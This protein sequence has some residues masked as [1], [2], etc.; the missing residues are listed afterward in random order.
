MYRVVRVSCVLLTAVA[1]TA[2]GTPAPDPVAPPTARTTVAPGP[3]SADGI[4][5][6]YY[7]KDGNGGYDV[8]NYAVSVS[9]DPPAKQL[10]GDTVV[11]ATAT[12]ALTTF[13]LDLI[14]FDVTSVEVDGKPAEAAREGKHELVITPATPIAAGAKF[15]TRVRYAGVPEPSEDKGL[16]AGGWQIAKSGGAFAAGEPHVASHWFPVNDHPSDKATFRLAAR[17]PDGWSV[18][19]NGR[20]EPAVAEGGWTTYNWVEPTRIATYL[21]TIGI[22]KWTFERSTLADGTPVVNAYAPGTED[23]KAVQ[24]RMPEVLDF[25]STKFGPYPQSAAGGI[26]LNENI[27]FSLETQ[28][29]PIYAKWAELE[30]VV[31]ELAHQWFG[32]TVSVKTW[33]DICLNECFASYAQWLWAEAKEGV[34]LDERY[35][36]EV[37]RNQD[38]SR[39]W[40]RKLYDMGAGNEFTAVYDKGQLALHALRRQIGEDAFGKVLKDWIAAHKDGNASWPD[41]EDLATNVSGQ[42]LRPFFDAWF[43]DAKQ[44]ADEFLYPGTLR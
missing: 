1:F 2:C 22:D 17:V 33:A 3:A 19:S 34:N 25:L 13:N 40:N 5:D 9:Y 30:V 15:A 6:P 21:T 4:G 29:R 23:K 44:P 26:Y 20:E 37:A 10:T 42:N 28:G 31:H 41:F 12:S 18:V 8:E 39:F 32:D 43:R 27:G 38:R 36:T 11:T 24:A 7:P 14:G 35:R 16:G